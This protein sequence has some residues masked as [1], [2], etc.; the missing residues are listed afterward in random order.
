M[1]MD[2]QNQPVSPG[3][4]QP[5]ANAANTAPETSPVNQV[6][7]PTQ[8][9]PVVSAAPATPGV[10]AQAA[11]VGGNVKTK[12]D[13]VYKKEQQ[14]Q[15]TEQEISNAVNLGKRLFGL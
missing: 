10:G 4:S 1:S 6:V 15:T 9:Q 13:Q 3:Q 8:P 12:L 14:L 11:A 5:A 7:T 2:A